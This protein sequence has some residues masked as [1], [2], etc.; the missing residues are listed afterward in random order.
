MKVF[1]AYRTALDPNDKQCGFFKR[2]AGTTRFVFN[3]GLANWKLQYENGEKPSAYSLRKL[4]NSIKDEQCPWV[5]ELPY[6]VTE[7][8]FYDLGNAFQHFFR[9]VKNG[10]DKAG[11]PKFKHRNGKQAFAL[12][13]AKVEH[14]RVR[15]T[16]IGWVKLKERGYI[17]TEGVKLLTYARISERA[18]RWFISVGVEKE[19]PDPINGSVLV[20]GVDFGLKSLAVCSDGTVYEN[21]TPLRKAERKL[22]R[23]Q[24]ELSRRKKGSCNWRKTKLKLQRQHAKVADVRKH[25][26]HQ[27]SHDLVVNKRPAAVV[28]EDLNVSGMTKNHHL[29]KAISDVGFYELRRQIEYKA[30]WHGVEVVLADQWYPSSKTCHRCRWKDE[31]LKLSDRRFVCPECGLDCNRDLNAA[32]NLAALVNRETHGDCPGS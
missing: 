2:C 10:E 16:G 9:R 8:A 14:D 23:L 11:Y 29:A 5:R 30:E 28:I 18:G 25:I 15:L 27:V 19:I 17:P 26:L 20:V 32:V 22:K 7:A 31:N 4:F 6:A 21:L 12:R 13:D 24:R 1:K 3:W